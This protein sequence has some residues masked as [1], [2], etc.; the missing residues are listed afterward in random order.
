LGLLHGPAVY[1]HRKHI[2][3]SFCVLEKSIVCLLLLSASYIVY[4]VYILHLSARH[5]LLYTVQCMQANQAST[6]KGENGEEH[7][8]SA[9]NQDE[10]EEALFW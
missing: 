2:L 4:C 1:R 5:T 9:E 7:A 10:E 6:M 8:L 3:Y